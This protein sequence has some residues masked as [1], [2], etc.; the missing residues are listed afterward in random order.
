MAVMAGALVA[1]PNHEGILRMAE[2][3]CGPHLDCLPRHGKDASVFL[4]HCYLGVVFVQEPDK[5]K[6]H[7]LMWKGCS[8]LFLFLQLY[9]FLLFN[10]LLCFCGKKPH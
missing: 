2:Q 8:L 10:T 3:K 1:I 4:S 9:I 7:F 5:L 6:I